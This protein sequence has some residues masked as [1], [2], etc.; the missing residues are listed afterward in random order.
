M[1]K[2]EYRD[3]GIGREI[4]NTLFDISKQMKLRALELECFA[5]NARA[6]HLYK[7]LGFIKVGRIPEK[8]LF[9]NKYIDDI[10]VYK[11]L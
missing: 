4:M 8:F 10:L 2:K 9:K 6:L 7:E 5:V 11:K 3:A 1:I